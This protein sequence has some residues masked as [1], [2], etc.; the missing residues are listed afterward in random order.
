MTVV[1]NTELNASG[2]PVKGVKVKISVGGVG[3]ATASETGSVVGSVSAT[4][5]TN[6]QWSFDLLANSQLIPAGTWYVVSRTYPASAGGTGRPI[7]TYIYV[8][9]SATAVNYEDIIVSE[10]TAPRLTDSELTDHLAHADPHAQYLTQIEGDARYMA[11]GG[12]ASPGTITTSNISDF[13][14][15]VDTKLNGSALSRFA[16]PTT[17]VGM[18]SKKLT[19]LANGTNITDAL[20]VGQLNDHIA[21]ADPHV[22]AGYARIVVGTATGPPTSGTFQL[23]QLAISGDMR[24]W[25]CSVAG[26]P[27]TWVPA[28]AKVTVS[29]TA[30][31]NP[32]NGDIHI[33]LL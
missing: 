17:D 27:G 32:Y 10:P 24:I 18:G 2:Q 12:T 3:V 22:A 23:R 7:E 13:N 14:T 15:A 21:A 33:R 5:G 11:I 9:V 19:G 29:A 8:P 28:N 30:P 26:T 1:Q 6:G 4:T 20:T 25:I 31:S 16:P